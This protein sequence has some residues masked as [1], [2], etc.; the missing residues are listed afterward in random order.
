MRTLEWSKM[1]L[2]LHPEVVNR[3]GKDFVVL[4]REEFIA[5]QELLHDAEDLLDLRAAKAAQT[6]TP[7]SL[8][9]AKRELGLT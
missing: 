2:Q 5:L 8:E 7:L 6:D 1:M 9:T 3:N 4:P